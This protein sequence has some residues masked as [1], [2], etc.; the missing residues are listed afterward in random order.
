MGYFAC[1][2]DNHVKNIAVADVEPEPEAV[3][4]WVD[5]TSTEPR[6]GPNWEYKDGQFIMPPPPPK[7]VLV[8]NKAM[9]RRVTPEFWPKVLEAAN[10][11]AEVKAWLDDFKTIGMFDITAPETRTKMKFLLDKNLIPPVHLETILIDFVYG[12][13]KDMI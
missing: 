1:I 9:I 7:L 10:T 11:D 12:F 8:N 3:G 4:F 5:V 13:E 2:V 6:P